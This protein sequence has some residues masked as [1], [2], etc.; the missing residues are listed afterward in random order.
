MRGRKKK[1]TQETRE[2][3]QAWPSGMWLPWVRKEAVPHFWAQLCMFA[4]H[5]QGMVWHS[6]ANWQES[7]ERD[8][9]YLQGIF[10]KFFRWFIRRHSYA[11][12][13]LSVCN[14]SHH[15]HFPWS[16]PGCSGCQTWRLRAGMDKESCRLLASLCLNPPQYSV[17]THQPPLKQNIILKLKKEA[18]WYHLNYKKR[19]TAMPN[20]LHEETADKWEVLTQGSDSK[21]EPLKASAYYSYYQ[22]TP[23]FHF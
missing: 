15:G 16:S 12:P 1:K 11:P 7:P 17:F 10:S 6:A 14:L 18:D 13:N 2:T 4:P 9:S 19:N 23:T 3:S 5:R 8:S 20:S 22:P 21:H